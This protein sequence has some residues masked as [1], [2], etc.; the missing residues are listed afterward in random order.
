MAQVRPLTRTLSP[1]GERGNSFAV[2][3]CSPSCVV[4]RRALFAVV[5]SPSCVVRRR[6]FS[7]DN[8][9]GALSS[10]NH[11][12]ANSRAAAVASGPARKHNF[13]HFGF[14]SSA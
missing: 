9:A 2:V 8:R 6:Y 7:S 1:A 12:V 4:R 5:R 11:A 14:I 10:A 13:H 3:R